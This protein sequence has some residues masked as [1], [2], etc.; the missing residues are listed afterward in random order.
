[1]TV[2]T[3]KSS[4]KAPGTYGLTRADLPELSEAPVDPHAWFGPESGA[5]APPM[6]LEIGSGKGTFLAQQAPLEPGVRWLGVEYARPFWLHAADRVRRLGLNN[7]RV[8][9]AEAGALVRHYLPDASLRQVHIYFP[10]PWPKARHHKRRLVQAPFLQDL[11]RLLQDPIEGGSE[12]TS[13]NTPAGPAGGVRGCVRLMTDHADYFAWMEDHAERVSPWFER[14]PYAAP[15]SA[16]QGEVA[17]TNFERKYRVEGRSFSGMI[18]RKRP[19]ATPP[20]P[21][22][23][24]LEALS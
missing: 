24:P 13:E 8:M 4:Q 6:D 20:E 10:D 12:A 23:P 2:G 1:M 21:P 11:W 18:L 17:G 15:A 22:T 5:S 3:S 14:L 16:G 9:H 19:D 7:V